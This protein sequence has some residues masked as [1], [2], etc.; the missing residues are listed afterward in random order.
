[1]VDI[2]IKTFKKTN[3]DGGSLLEASPTV[4]L[5][6]TIACSY[7]VD[8]LDLDQIAAWDSEDFPPVSL[9]YAAKPKY[10]ARIYA[11]EGLKLAAFLSEVPLPPRTHRA[12]ARRL[13]AWAREQGMREI[14]SLEGLPAPE[15]Q[16]STPRLWGIGSTDRARERLDD[17]GVDQLQGGMISGVSGVLLNEGRWEGFDVLCLVA[18]SRPYLPDAAAAAR[19]VQGVDALLPQVEI[20]TEPLERRAEAIQE[21]MAQIQ[22]QA[23]PALPQPV[24]E[25]YR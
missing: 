18:E 4:G 23:K 2:E 17:A 14:I 12:V 11:H 9:I 20:P 6:S 16:E 3:L 25:M 5:A 21:Q 1:M 10:P 13:L 8:A 15:D 22:A 24:P 7:L 19:L